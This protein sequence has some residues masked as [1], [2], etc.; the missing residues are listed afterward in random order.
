MRQ[1]AGIVLR[2]AIVGHQALRHHPRQ[3]RHLGA[4]ALHPFIRD[5]QRRQIRIRKIAVIGRVFL[6]AHG[7]GFAGIRIEQHRGLLNCVTILNLLN[8]PTHLV[9][10][11]LLHELETVQILDLTARTQGL[12]GLAHRHV[13]VA[14]KAAFLHVAV[15]NANP[16]HDLVQ[17]FGIGHRLGAGSH[18]GLGHDLQQRRAGT[19]QVNAGL[20]DKVFVQRLAGVFFQMGAHQAHRHFFIAEKELDTPALYHRDFKLANLVA[21][22]QIGVKII[23]ACKDAARC[24]M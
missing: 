5:D 10:N 13:G 8:L 21:L 11:G 6:G 24:D 7:A 12:A 1:G 14:T 16:G 20:P 23:L 9:V 15:A 17:L 4:H 2:E 18:V 19:V 3:F 22:G